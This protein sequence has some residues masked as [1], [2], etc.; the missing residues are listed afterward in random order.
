MYNT[1]TLTY[2]LHLHVNVNTLYLD[3][4]EPTR[5]LSCTRLCQFENCSEHRKP[6]CESVC[7][8]FSF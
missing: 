4:L 1:F 3:L 2:V 8:H 7:I 6:N 5:C